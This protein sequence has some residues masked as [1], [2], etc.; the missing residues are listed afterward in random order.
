MNPR[1]NPGG[2]P[3]APGSQ[4]HA[5][6]ASR[7]SMPCPVDGTELKRSFNQSATHACGDCKGVLF[8]NDH[9]ARIIR[10]NGFDLL[11]L[12]PGHD[13]TVPCPGCG[14]I[15]KVFIIDG[16]EIDLCGKCEFVWMDEGEFV[17]IK[18]FLEKGREAR[19]SEMAKTSD[20][21]FGTIDL[22]W[23][24]SEIDDWDR[25]NIIGAML[26]YLFDGLL[27]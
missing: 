23:P 16:I 15:M 18:A 2:P 26:E 3:D 14:L 9:L 21:D 7:G 6:A 12:K 19:A 20:F 4:D 22:L 17:K 13:R 1:G 5:Q 8:S 10:N 11:K 27:R 24:S 25:A